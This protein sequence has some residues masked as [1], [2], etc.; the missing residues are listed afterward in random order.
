MR[1]GSGSCEESKAMIRGAS[2][3]EKGKLKGGEVRQNG[4]RRNTKYG[5]ACPNCK[6]CPDETV[7]ISLHARSS[8][9]MSAGINNGFESVHE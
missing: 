7:L 9:T 6:R 4:G 3:N 8:H 2:P 1:A 5:K